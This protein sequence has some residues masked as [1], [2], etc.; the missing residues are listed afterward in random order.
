MCHRLKGNGMEIT[1]NRFELFIMIFY[2]LDYYQDDNK[3]E[4]LS[5][6]LSDMSPFIFADEGSADPAVYSEFCD[7]VKE[8]KIEIENS[9]EVACR[10]IEWINQPYVIEAFEWITKDEWEENTKKYLESLKESK[11]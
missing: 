7:F 10:Y 3:G 4:E 6:F 11:R 5:I 1:M 2:V 8:D 9:F